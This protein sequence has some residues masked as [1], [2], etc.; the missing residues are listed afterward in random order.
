AVNPEA[1][2]APAQLQ[3]AS[4]GASSLALKWSAVQ[5]ADGY[6][7]F[8]DRKYLGTTSD[9]SY[10]VQGLQPSTS[11]SIYVL[12]VSKVG[13]SIDEVSP[14]SIL[15]VATEGLAAYVPPQIKNKDELDAA[16][17]RENGKLTISVTEAAALNTI[18][19]HD[20]ADFIITADVN[21][22]SIDIL[23][24]DAVA[25]ALAA[26]GGDGRLSVIWGHVTYVIPAGALDRGTD[27][28][29]SIAP[30]GDEV[31]EELGERAD[32]AELTLLADPL[33]FRISGRAEDGSYEDISDFEGLLL[34]RIFTLSGEDAKQDR[35]IGVIY[36]PD[37]GEFR[38]VA[39]TAT[40]QQNGTVK[41]EL[42]RD[43]N[44][45]YSVATT[46]FSFH[47]IELDWARDAI[48][49]AT[50][51]LLVS[52]KSASEF[53]ASDDITRA[54]F[55]SI[56]T[57]ALGILPSYGGSSFADV[58]G[59]TAFA[60]DIA[61]AAEAGLITG[62]SADAFVPDGAITRQEMAVVLGRALT[63]SGLA[64]DAD[65]A[66]LDR[67]GDRASISAYARQS[68]AWLA[69][70]GILKG[71]S[72]SAFSPST[73]VTKAQATVAVMRLLESLRGV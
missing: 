17:S 1:L 26:K 20:S 44:S 15:N 42:I 12:A 49:L 45:I 51:S 35:L 71:V 2:A 16:V 28:R 19:A 31:T 53:G 69:E 55:V 27:I 32:A 56:I 46:D 57:R 59:D 13:E 67:F 65:I 54:E 33:D 6:E 60:G 61:A 43:G 18:K 7:V 25:A 64:N 50:A 21:A 73:N 70:L 30:P 68:A 40:E 8:V 39:S 66:T 62:K 23:L 22:D 4:K 38:P 41:I 34:H 29:I 5:G 63:L 37:S 58:D 14:A 10:N 47:D 3:A 11:Y 24:P 52:G 48:E 72:A 9:T 36:L